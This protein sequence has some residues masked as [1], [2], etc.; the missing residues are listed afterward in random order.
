MDCFRAERILTGDSGGG[1]R[2]LLAVAAAGRSLGKVSFCSLEVLLPWSS[3]SLRCRLFFRLIFSLRRAAAFAA[4]APA[5]SSSEV[6]VASAFLLLFG[7]V[8]VDL[9]A[10][11]V[12]V[13]V[14]KRVCWKICAQ[15]CNSPSDGLFHLILTRKT[16]LRLLRQRKNVWI[17][18]RRGSRVRVPLQQV[19]RGRGRLPASHCPHSDVMFKLVVIKYPFGPLEWWPRAYLTFPIHPDLVFVMIFLDGWLSSTQNRKFFFRKL[20]KQNRD[21]AF[22]RS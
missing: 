16:G 20:T 12:V 15:L 11:A 14:M 13:V 2:R 19:G 6:V 22:V 18:T 4:A 7:L 10:V 17:L 9:L 5:S 3:S 1:C 21:Y 8:L